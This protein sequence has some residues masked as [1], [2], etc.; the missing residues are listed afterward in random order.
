[1]S[2]SETKYEGKIS[3]RLMYGMKSFELLMKDS[4]FGSIKEKW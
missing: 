3:W 4:N 2:L 1:M